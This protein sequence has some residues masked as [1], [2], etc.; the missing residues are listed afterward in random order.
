MIRKA[1]FNDMP[2]LLELA[3]DLVAESRFASF[4]FVPSRVEETFVRLLTT[5]GRIFV[6]ERDGEIVGGIACG[7]G[8][9][10]F[11]EVPITYEYGIFVTKRHRGSP[12]ARKLMEAYLRWA[13]ALAP[14]VNISVG[15]TTGID[16][17]RTVKLWQLVAKR[18]GVQLKVI[19]PA[20]SNLG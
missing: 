4:G 20:L 5:G 19:G 2:R 6:A 12:A 10:W 7:T 8:G 11:S 18:I 14:V 13:I 3:R 15:V 9:D 16:T 1:T 17:D